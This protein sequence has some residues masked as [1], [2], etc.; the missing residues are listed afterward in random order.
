VKVG[1]RVEI[2]IKV[3]KRLYPIICLSFTNCRKSL[4][5]LYISTFIESYEDVITY[6][7][8][9]RSMENLPNKYKD[10]V[11][12]LLKGFSDSEIAEDLG[13]TRQYINRIKKNIK[14]FN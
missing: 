14:I 12:L 2:L 1:Q 3:E 13:V 11:I 5:I 10:I 9:S 6:I 8:L 4:Y 7:D